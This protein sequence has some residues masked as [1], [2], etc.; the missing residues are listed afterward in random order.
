MAGPEELQRIKEERVQRA[1]TYLAYGFGPKEGPQLVIEE[2]AEV[3]DDEEQYGEYQES[4][5]DMAAS[6]ANYGDIKLCDDDLWVDG[7][8]NEYAREKKAWRVK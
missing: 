7:R 3:D 4:R 8:F 1:R 2:I 6:S 5:I